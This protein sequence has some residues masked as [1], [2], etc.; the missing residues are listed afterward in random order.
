MKTISHV[1]L[2]VGL[3]GTLAH[4]QVMVYVSPAGV[5]KGH[6]LTPSSAA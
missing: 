5:S 2:L 6:S 1:P 3:S 4:A